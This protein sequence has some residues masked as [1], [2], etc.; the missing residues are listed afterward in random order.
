MRHLLF[1]FT[2]FTALGCGSVATDEQTASIAEAL[3]ITGSAVLQPTS[4]DLDAAGT[5]DT[6]ANTQTGNEDLSIKL[7]N[8]DPNAVYL[9][10]ID[11][12]EIRNF[13]T[14]ANGS[15]LLKLSNQPRGQELA[16]PAGMS[17][18]TMQLIEVKDLSGQ[19]ILSGS[20]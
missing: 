7:D 14:N 3:I 15:A 9:L 6:K 17:V 13:G 5:A 1:A 16:L 2:I 10:V 18:L 8:L 19:V 11:G 12:V 4:V 20:F